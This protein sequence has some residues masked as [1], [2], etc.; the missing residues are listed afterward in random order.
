MSGKTILFLSHDASRTGAPMVLLHLLRWLKQNTT[1]SLVILLRRDGELLADFRELGTTYVYSFPYAPIQGLI[2]K[3]R[4]AWNTYIGIRGYYK[5]LARDLQNHA[6]DLIYSNSIGNGE[7]LDFLAFLNCKVITHVHELEYGIY[8][9][10]VSNFKHILHYTNQYIAVS[11]AVK[12]NLIDRYQISEHLIEVIYEFIPT[13]TIKNAHT[14]TDIRTSLNIPD[15]AFVIGASGTTDLRKGFDLFI[16]LAKEVYQQEGKDCY[17]VWVGGDLNSSYH[18]M[19][20]LDSEKL[21]LQPFIR[22]IGSQ[23]SPLD[24]FSIFDVFT[25]L[26]REDPYPLVC[27]EVAI[28]GKPIV[29][30]EN[31]GGIPEMVRN[32]NGFVVPYLDLKKMAEKLIQLKNEPHTRTRLGYNAKQWVENKHDVAVAVPQILK[33]IN[34]VDAAMG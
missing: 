11:Q 32:N 33:L 21:G 14:R 22:L 25:L 23:K 17:F 34:T 9:N 1:L 6:I 8:A 5:K 10:G 18:Y 15:D 3:V 2:G 27:L 24:Y 31:A 26:S 16:L 19:A 4:A 7:V 28:L 30:F 12:D 29:C 13:Q 20:S